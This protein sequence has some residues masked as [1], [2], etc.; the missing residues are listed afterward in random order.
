[1]LKSGRDFF[2]FSLGVTLPARDSWN[3]IGLSGGRC[4]NMG[5]EMMLSSAKIMVHAR[6]LCFSGIRILDSG[7]DE[8]V[9]VNGMMRPDKGFHQRAHAIN[10]KQD[11]AQQESN[12]SITTRLVME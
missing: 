7:V 1:M 12:Q 4:G 11:Q 6:K 2:Q 5:S 10:V 8:L 9:A 3:M